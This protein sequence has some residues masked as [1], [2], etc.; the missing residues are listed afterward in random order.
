MRINIRKSNQ[1][2]EYLKQKGVVNEQEFM[3]TFTNKAVS[4]C[5][6]M[7]LHPEIIPDELF[8]EMMDMLPVDIEMMRQYIKEN[9]RPDATKEIT[10]EKKRDKRKQKG[11]YRK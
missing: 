8:N 5:T 3:N 1:L 11:K 9:Y 2:S 6:Y 7:C 4:I 10:V